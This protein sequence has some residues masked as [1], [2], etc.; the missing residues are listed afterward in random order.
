M[1]LINLDKDGLENRLTID[2]NL[3]INHLK[4]FRT[5]I[6][7]EFCTHIRKLMDKKGKKVYTTLFEQTERRRDDDR[8]LTTIQGRFEKSWCECVHTFL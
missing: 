5:L 4:M 3:M 2:K 6:S 7:R 8:L 1:K